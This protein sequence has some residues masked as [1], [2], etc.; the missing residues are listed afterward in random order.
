MRNIFPLQEQTF[1]IELNLF[2]HFFSKASQDGEVQTEKLAK[3][4]DMIYM[5]MRSC[6][7]TA[8]PFNYVSLASSFSILMN[9]IS[10]VLWVWKPYHG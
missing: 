5:F 8:L 2:S 10:H 1:E 3:S 6:Y 9:F 7:S 4:G